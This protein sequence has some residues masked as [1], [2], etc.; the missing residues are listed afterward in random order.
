MMSVTLWPANTLTSSACGRGY[1]SV[2]ALVCGVGVRGRV[3]GEV[4]GRVREKGVC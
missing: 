3:R 4:R 2:F 1:P